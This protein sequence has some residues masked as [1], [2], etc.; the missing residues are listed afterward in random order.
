M[1]NAVLPPP[2]LRKIRRINQLSNAKLVRLLLV[3]E[4]SCEALAAESGIHY[5]TV[6]DYVG[7]MRNEGALF[8]D[9]YEADSRGAMRVKIFKLGFGEDAIQPVLTRAERSKRY[10][11]NRKA[12]EL[13]VA[14]TLR[15]K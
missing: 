9:H 12:R 3:G 8:I 15:P 11:E 7:A 4:L 2:A 1:R 5:M 6:L 13:Q 10:R 14:L